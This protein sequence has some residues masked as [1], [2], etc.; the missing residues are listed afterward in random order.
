MQMKGNSKDQNK[1]QW[2]IRQKIEKK[3]INPK[4]GSLRK[5]IELVNSGQTDKEK[6]I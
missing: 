5:L 1:D 4:A 2:N 3:E 6:N